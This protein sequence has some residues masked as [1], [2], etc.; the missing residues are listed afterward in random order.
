MIS[1]TALKTLALAIRLIVA[2][3]MPSLAIARARGDAP[4]QARVA[5]QKGGGEE[6]DR[7]SP[8]IT[9]LLCLFGPGIVLVPVLYY[10]LRL[11]R[12]AMSR[13]DES[14]ERQRRLVELQERSV[15]LHKESVALLREA[16][17]LLERPS[18]RR[19]GGL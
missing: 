10:S 7:G 1:K 4:R 9:G 16:I 3:G 15:A 12:R 17:R 5:P 11:Q 14:L 6:A 19:I 8:G 18:E 13:V 2:S